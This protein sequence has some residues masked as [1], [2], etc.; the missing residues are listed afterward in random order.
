[1]DEKLRDSFPE[2]TSVSLAD[3]SEYAKQC[4]FH[5]WY[6]DFSDDGNVWRRGN[7]ERAK[8]EAQSTLDRAYKAVF[9]VWHAAHYNARAGFSQFGE[10]CTGE[11]AE[12]LVAELRT[13]LFP[14]VAG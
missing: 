9:Q 12:G 3:F 4:R 2:S 11:E 14:E 1:M 6:Y 7:L 13:K 10:G 5:D 8:L